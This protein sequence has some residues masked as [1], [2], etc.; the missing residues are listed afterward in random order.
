MG[1]YSHNPAPLI[2][3]PAK[4]AK[5]EHTHALIVG[6][7][8]YAAGTDWDLNGPL[9]DAMRIR[10]WLLD[11]GVPAGQ[12]HLHV[13]ALEANQA[14]L[15][16]LKVCHQ[17]ATDQALRHTIESL[18][19]I[20]VAQDDLFVLYWAG[21][22]LIS[23]EHH[24]L[25]LTEATYQDWKSYSVG[26]LRSS[27]ANEN[28]PGFAQQIFLFDTCRSFHRHP[29]SPPPAVPLPLG[30]QMSKSQFIFFA[31]QEGQAA[32]NLGQEQCGLFTKM[33]LEKIASS[34]K[35]KNAWPPEMENIATSVQQMFAE[36]PQQYPVY[37]YY[38][39]WKGNETIDSLPADGVELSGAIDYLAALLAKHLGMSRQ[40]NDVIRYLR[41]HGPHGNEVVINAV[42]G[43]SAIEDYRNIL[44]TCLDFSGSI[45]SLK[46]VC[47]L[48]LGTKAAAPI[49]DHAFSLLL[50]ALDA[51]GIAYG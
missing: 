40:R 8:R 10:T 44:M 19:M 15:N 45:Q 3:L 48:L 6:I 43:N 20:P 37:K 41:L 12:I 28:C 34:K 5:P 33:L 1:G 39:D 27:F 23:A 42:T 30:R 29:E 36:N 7:E 46:M 13:S 47:S 21:H 51:E 49:V 24:C 4:P 16:H 31:S 25:L 26:N 9:N 18:K 17:E 14:K 32:N 35:A 50:E 11:S 38:R 2:R 22:G